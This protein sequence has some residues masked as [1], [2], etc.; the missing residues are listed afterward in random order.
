MKLMLA[1]D[2]MLGRG[3]DQVLPHPGLAEIFESHVRS[4]LTYVRLAEARNGP[5]S[6]PVSFDYPWGDALEQLEAAEPERRIVNLETAVTRRGRAEPKGINY[7]MTPENLPALAAAGID[8]CAIANNHV[9]DWG[10]D[11]LSDTID[12]LDAAGL[13]HAGAGQ[14]QEQAFEPAVL[15]LRTG[16]RLLV[17]G[18]AHG[19]AGVPRHWAAGERRPGVALLPDLSEAAVRSMA[20]RIAD[21]RHPGDVVLV[22]VHWGPNWGYAIGEER[23]FAHGLID[24]AGA[25]I[26]QGHSSHH[27]K[28]IERYRGKLILYGCGDLLNDYEGIAGHEHFRPELALIYLPELDRGHTC[29]LEL[30]PF[31]ISRFRLHAASAAEARW[32]ANAIES[33]SPGLGEHRPVLVESIFG[34]RGV[35]GI[36]VRFDG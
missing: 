27:P 34:V 16:G 9:L 6:R 3:I 17:Y 7:R 25:D 12:A 31:R 36:A 1:G 29:A 35:T 26:V 28:G 24:R 11:G 14:H 30:L 20:E 2:V 15:S 5:I 8:C 13:A 19:S 22:S 21:D 32:L 18:I 23:R 4:A 10:P 33:H